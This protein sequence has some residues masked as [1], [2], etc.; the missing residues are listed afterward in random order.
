MSVAI[1]TPI[2]RAPH[3]EFVTSLIKTLGA[4]PGT[5]WLHVTGHANT[6]RVRNLLAHW[7]LTK[8]DCTDVVFIDDDIAWTPTDFARLMS[9]DVDVVA[10]A[11]QRRSDDQTFCGRLDDPDRQ[12]QHGELVS[13]QAATAFMRISRKAFE[14]LAPT[15]DWF[16]YRDDKNV[17]AYFDYDIGIAGNGQRAYVGE[18]FWFCD[19]CRE[20]GIEVWIDPYVRL[21][22][23]HTVG[24]DLCMGDMMRKIDYDESQ[25]GHLVSDQ[26][27]FRSHPTAA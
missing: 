12:K 10:G 26:P 2:A 15:R 23:F 1:L 24:L 22:H 27:V 18:D 4:F 5:Q 20:N 3:P 13:G 21:K 17:K 8:T 6:P 14:H 7:A 19:Q 25:A 9:H 16:E 11:P